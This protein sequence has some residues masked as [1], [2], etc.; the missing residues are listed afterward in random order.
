M[1]PRHITIKQTGDLRI[2]GKPASISQQLSQQAAYAM[3]GFY[4]PQDVFSHDGDAPRTDYCAAL[5]L[6][7]GQK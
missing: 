2:V 4:E 7:R 6:A 1:I 3:H 5:S